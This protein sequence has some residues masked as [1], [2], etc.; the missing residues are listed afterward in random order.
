MNMFALQSLSF[1]VQYRG[2][3]GEPSTEPV[4][5]AYTPPDALA[6][7]FQSGRYRPLVGAGTNQGDGSSL[8]QN[9]GASNEK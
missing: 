3:T 2:V 5:A 4:F 1:C 7:V 6:A 8:K 9:W